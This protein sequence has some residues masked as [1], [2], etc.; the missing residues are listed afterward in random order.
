MIAK[1]EEEAKQQEQRRVKE[2]EEISTAWNTL[3]ESVEKLVAENERL[4]AEKERFEL[5]TE[6]MRRLVRCVD[7]PGLE[8]DFY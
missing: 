5:I 3:R 7:D 6:G 2:S 1:L 4:K 8:V